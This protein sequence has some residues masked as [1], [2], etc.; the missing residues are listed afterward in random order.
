MYTNL[1][2]K[3]NLIPK[4]YNFF[5]GNFLNLFIIIFNLICFAESHCSTN[6]DS[7][8]LQKSHEKK[9]TTFY[10][11]KIFSKSINKPKNL[12]N[13]GGIWLHIFCSKFFSM[14]NKMLSGKFQIGFKRQI[15][16]RIIQSRTSNFCLCFRNLEVTWAMIFNNWRLLRKTSYFFKCPW[17][18]SSFNNIC[19]FN[20]SIFFIV[21]VKF[22]NQ[23][24]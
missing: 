14:S 1:F 10:E 5:H 18:F 4:N 8:F 6:I 2:F 17:T 21:F 15:V 16:V 24:I 11:I 20:C 22:I 9:T 23:F 7:N 12:T 19:F 13:P 3:P